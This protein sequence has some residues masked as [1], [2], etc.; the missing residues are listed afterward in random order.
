MAKTNT[1]YSQ[2]EI[3]FL[4]GKLVELEQYIQSNPFHTLDDRLGWRA[5]KNGDEISYVIAT[6]EVQRKDITQA[7]KDYADIALQVDKLREK[8]IAKIEAR[9]STKISKNAEDFLKGQ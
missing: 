4:E 9:G 6:K 1:T 2:Y 8:D 7:I 5:G 3:E